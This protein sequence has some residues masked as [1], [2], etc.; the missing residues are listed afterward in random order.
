M[1]KSS[2]DH[3]GLPILKRLIRM[4]RIEI[5]LTILLAG[6]S[7]AQGQQ[8]APQ[9][10]P[11]DVDKVCADASRKSSSDLSDQSGILDACQA[12]HAAKISAEAASLEATVRLIPAYACASSAALCLSGIFT[13]PGEAY[14]WVCAGTSLAASTFEKIKEGTIAGT[15]ANDIKS[16][17]YVGASFSALD[18]ANNIKDI[19]SLVKGAPKTGPGCTLAIIGAVTEI[20]TVA[21]NYY[22]AGTLRDAEQQSR[23]MVRQLAGLSSIGDINDFKDIKDR[24][25]EKLDPPD[26]KLDPELEAKLEELTGMSSKDLMNYQGDPVD[27]LNKL[28]EKA[29]APPQALEIAKKLY[30]KGVGPNGA[31][32]ASRGRRTAESFDALG[33]SGYGSGGD[34]FEGGRGLAGA[35][36]FKGDG[37]RLFK[38]PRLMTPEELELDRYHDIF[39]RVTRRYEAKA[40]TELELLPWALKANQFANSKSK[41]ARS[42]GGADKLRFTQ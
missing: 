27:L 37:S 31:Y 30:A 15:L 39:L 19:V 9:P 18:M 12:A 32:I 11:V 40:P 36:K 17:N 25:G 20:G 22:T 1:P 4:S 3:L 33:T 29:G 34:G 7:Y 2:C 13:G 6:Q 28:L 14:S 26:L 8:P 21:T 10:S 41:G 23:D 38:D 24:D 5:Y 16:K 42:P 35:K